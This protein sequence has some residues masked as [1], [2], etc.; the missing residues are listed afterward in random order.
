LKRARSEIQAY[1]ASGDQDNRD[2]AI[3]WLKALDQYERPAS[4]LL[5]H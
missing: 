4:A 5:S 2:V 3:A 1:L